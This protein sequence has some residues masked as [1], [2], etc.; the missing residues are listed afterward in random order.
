MV[1]D[2]PTVEVGGSKMYPSGVLVI[3]LW[4]VQLE[5]SLNCKAMQIVKEMY[6]LKGLISEKSKVS[7]S[8]KSEREFNGEFCE[9]SWPR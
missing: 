9:V 4:E 3:S 6:W 2:S 7:W 8:Q 1:L 5:Q